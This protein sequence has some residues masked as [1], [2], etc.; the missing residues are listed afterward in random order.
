MER[1]QVNFPVTREEHEAIKKLAKAE[2]RS[3]KQ[4]FLT[5]LEKLYPDWCKEEK[6][7]GPK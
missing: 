4:L 7:N 3:V 6:E 2:R 1:R 5:M